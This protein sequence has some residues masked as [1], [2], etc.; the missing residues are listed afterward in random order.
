MRKE[1]GEDMGSRRAP[2]RKPRN[3]SGAPARAGGGEEKKQ[4]QDALA[5]TGAPATAGA[6]EEKNKG[7]GTP[8]QNTALGSPM[9][10]SPQES[11]P[12]STGA[13]TCRGAG[14]GRGGRA[15]GDRRH[16]GHPGGRPGRVG[17]RAGVLQ[18]F[19]RGHARRQRGGLRRHPAPGSGPREPAAGTPGP[20]YAHEGGSGPGRACPSNRTASTSSRPISTWAS[21]MESCTWPS[22][23]RRTAFGCPST[24]SSAPW[25]KIGRSGRSASSFPGPART[26]RWACGR[27]GAPAG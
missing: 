9:M 11:A 4:G 15:G 6:G 22:R 25:P 21:A 3:Q 17:R 24:S 8:T 18:G 2:R 20:A 12:A 19:L 10:P 23:S 7:K 26:G 27:S 1:L 5:T 13:V 16:V 14:S